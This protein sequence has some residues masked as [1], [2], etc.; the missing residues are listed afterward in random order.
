MVRV[1]V[2]LRAPITSDEKVL[3]DEIALHGDSI[4]S[5]TLLR[6]SGSM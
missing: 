5:L 4:H 6:R 2:V 1:P 3:G